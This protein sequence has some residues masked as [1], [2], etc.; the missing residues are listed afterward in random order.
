MLRKQQ[1]KSPIT[2]W[3]LTMSSKISQLFTEK[4]FFPLDGPRRSYAHIWSYWQKWEEVELTFLSVSCFVCSKGR[5]KCCGFPSRDVLTNHQWG[6]NL[7]AIF[8]ASG[9]KRVKARGENKTMKNIICI[10]ISKSLL[11]RLLLLL[12]LLFLS[13][14]LPTL[15]YS[16]FLF[17]TVCSWKKGEGRK[18]K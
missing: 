10:L 7:E 18:L 8:K 5:Q 3:N 14:D 12:W 16:Y 2:S 9:K 11:Q 1:W 6:D 17:C 4:A 15:F 13:W